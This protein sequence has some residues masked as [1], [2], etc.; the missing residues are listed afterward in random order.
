M[1]GGNVGAL[2]VGASLFTS[3]GTKY[4]SKCQLPT[5]QEVE[6][7]EEEANE[8]ECDEDD[9]PPLVNPCLMPPATTMYDR[10]DQ[11]IQIDLPLRADLNKRETVAGLAVGALKLR[12]QV[13]ASTPRIVP[14]KLLRFPF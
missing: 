7:V 1:E 14:T 12:E 13:L 6:V 5:L 8:E 9:V 11:E 2:V 10:P 3:Y 4:R